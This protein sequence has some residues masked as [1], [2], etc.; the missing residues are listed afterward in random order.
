MSKFWIFIILLYFKTSLTFTQSNWGGEIIK[1][2]GIIHV[3]NLANPLHHNPQAK[4]KKIWQIGGEDPGFIMNTIS[5]IDIDE[6]DCIYITDSSEKNAKVFSPTGQHIITFGKQGQGPGEFRIPRCLSILKNNILIIDPLIAYPMN[7]FILY[8]F[9]GNFSNSF[10]LDLKNTYYSK[11]IDLNQR[12]S[13]L[14]RHKIQFSKTFLKSCILLFTYSTIDMKYKENSLWVYKLKTRESVKIIAKNKIDPRLINLEKQNEQMF[15]KTQWC[16]NKNGDIFFI[17][18][19]YDYKIE[20]FDST[21]IL[22]SVIER[23]FNLPIKT[24][25]EF[26]K[27]L[28]DEQEWE[29]FYEKAG[30]K[31][32]WETLKEKPIIFNLGAYTRSMFCDDKNNL[33]VLTNESYP[34]KQSKGIISTLFKKESNKLNEKPTRLTFDVFNSDGKYLM[35]VPFDGDQPR[36]FVY[37]R[38]HIYFADLAADGFP[39]LFKYKINE[40]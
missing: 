7:R 25:T 10:N 33:W 11:D 34:S 16:H 5:S 36:C 24:K 22:K 8:D 39:W 37:K 14:S 31:V 9:Q 21:G 18:D 40:L 30:K 29:K 2:D 23:D 28:K 27:D 35:K 38:G 12:E 6:A 19:I 17:E 13:L 32:A 3:R 4:L 20:V 26:N 1:I 15:L